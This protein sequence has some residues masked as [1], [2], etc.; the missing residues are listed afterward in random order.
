V[1]V[2][3]TEEGRI[4]VAAFPFNFPTPVKKTER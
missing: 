4:V 3:E 2:E 1:A